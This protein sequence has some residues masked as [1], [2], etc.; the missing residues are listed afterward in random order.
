MKSF[1]LI[2]SEI[3]SLRRLQELKLQVGMNIR[4]IS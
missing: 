4:A 2:I 1:F 3:N